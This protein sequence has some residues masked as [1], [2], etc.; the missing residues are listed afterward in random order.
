MNKLIAESGIADRLEN[1][2]ENPEKFNQMM[3]EKAKKKGKC[4]SSTEIR[5]QRQF[6]EKILKD[7]SHTSFLHEQSKANAGHTGP[8]GTCSVMAHPTP[9]GHH[10]GHHRGHQTR[11]F[12]HSHKLAGAPEDA[13]KS[14]VVMVVGK[15]RRG[16][17]SGSLGKEM[18]TIKLSKY[19]SSKQHKTKKAGWIK[20]KIKKADKS[21]KS[22]H[23]KNQTRRR[24]KKLSTLG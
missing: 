11:K 2:L 14:V 13:F 6:L 3:K 8:Q 5:K 18:Q 21:R 7:F 12:P 23:D 24:R 15:P 16:E 17:R 22:K 19:P 4:I 20:K 1:I 10:R 9:F